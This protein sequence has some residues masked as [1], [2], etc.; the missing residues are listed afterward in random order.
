[1]KASQTWVRFR[2]SATRR[3]PISSAEEA[4][5]RLRLLPLLRKAVGDYEQQLK[6]FAD[7]TGGIV[8]VDG[9]WKAHT[10]GRESLRATAD[11]LSIVKEEL[12][13]DGAKV[14]VELSISAASIKRA[15]KAAGK[16]V[17][18]TTKRIVEKVKAAGAVER[19][20]RTTYEVR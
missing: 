16:P 6:E 12:G 2:G 1:M 19:G 18:E 15:V 13:M 10:D 7:E 8:T 17:G 11:A 3:A 4:Q 5:Y 20:T 14:A 9:V